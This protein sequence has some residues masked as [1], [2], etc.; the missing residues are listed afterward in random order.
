MR[1]KMPEGSRRIACVAV[2]LDRDIRASAKIAR[3]SGF[4]GLQF[5]PTL[6]TTDLLALSDSGRRE[7]LSILRGSD[8]QLVGL[9]TDV[10]GKGFRP[11]ADIDA[12]LD[13]LK[14]VLES[15]AR[16]QSSLVCVDLGSLPEPAEMPKA[17]PAISPDLAGAIIIDIT[18]AAPAASAPAEPPRPLDAPFA[19]AVDGALVELGRFADRLGVAV[20]FGSDLASFAAIHRALRSVACPWFG[21]NFDPAAALGDGWPLDEIFSRLAG[22]IHHVRARDALLGTDHRTR[23]VVIGSGSV[24]WDEMAGH[25][26]AAGYSGWISVDPIGLADARAGAVEGAGMLKRL[27]RR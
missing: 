17:A 16:F 7:I 12:V 15:A 5:D 22:Q 20:A 19:A 21:L 1:L 6:G 25:L 13:Q 2:A 3:S 27:M 8:L 10:G 4:S 26:E 9:R 24:K 11:G 14:K 23:P 18:G